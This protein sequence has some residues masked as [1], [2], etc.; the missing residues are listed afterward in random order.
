MAISDVIEGELQLQR[1]LEDM[2]LDLES[3]LD[4]NTL[5]AYRAI[6]KFNDRAITCDTLDTFL[7]SQGYHTR[8]EDVQRI[9][10]RIDASGDGMIDYNE[11]ADFISPKFKSYRH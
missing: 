5:A 1:R 9:I 8:H 11:F 10:R 4:Y 6:D 2:K 7:R 3:R